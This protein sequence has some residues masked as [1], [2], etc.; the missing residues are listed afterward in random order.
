MTER[1]LAI[2]PRFLSIIVPNSKSILR[3]RETHPFTGF[4]F[5]VNAG[6]TPE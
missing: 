5:H 6:T 3:K 4:I 2:P 1:R